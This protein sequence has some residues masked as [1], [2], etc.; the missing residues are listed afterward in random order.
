MY[1]N[2]WQNSWGHP[3]NV[4]FFFQIFQNIDG[5]RQINLQGFWNS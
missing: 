5:F 3:E 4:I 2:L 1:I